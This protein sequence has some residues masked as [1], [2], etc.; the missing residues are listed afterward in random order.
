MDYSNIWKYERRRKSSNFDLKEQFVNKN[1][2]ITGYIPA[3][4][5]KQNNIIP[6]EVMFLKNENDRISFGLDKKKGIT[7]LF[8][9]QGGDKRQTKENL[10]KNR[11]IEL[12]RKNN[13]IYLNNDKDSSAV[14]YKSSIKKPPVFMI[15]RMKNFLY[16]KQN[17][18]IMKDIVPFLM[19]KEDKIKEK[20]YIQISRIALEKRNLLLYKQT[21]NELNILRYNIENKK[22]YENKFLKYMEK[23]SNKLKNDKAI[24][25]EDNKYLRA[26]IYLNESE[27]DS[28]N[29]N[30]N[31]NE[32]QTQNELTDE[33]EDVEIDI[34]NNQIQN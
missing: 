22:Q 21:Q 9:R 16:N 23:L 15:N 31:I 17:K 34:N 10:N 25:I 28:E 24:Q 6:K 8:S 18:T 27:N 13:S 11:A 14:L 5:E 7:I 29:K 33:K 2:D 32:N 4:K 20:E 19:Q 1:K 30:R 26:F 3:A 12:E